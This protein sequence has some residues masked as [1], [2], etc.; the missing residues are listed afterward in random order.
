M[1][2]GSDLDFAHRANWADYGNNS[3][4]FAKDD[5]QNY[6]ALSGYVMGAFGIPGLLEKN[7][8]FASIHGGFIDQKSADRYDTFRLF[9]GAFAE[10]TDNL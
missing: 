6:V 1:A 5:F 4:T 2:G 3:I 9:G 8:V 10:V 7:R